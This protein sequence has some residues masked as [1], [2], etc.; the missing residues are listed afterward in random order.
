MPFQACPGIAS[1]EL[2]FEWDGQ[3][4]EIGYHAEQGTAWEE[5]DLMS[6]ATIVYTWWSTTLFGQL[7]NVITGLRAEAKGLDA[8]DSP[9]AIYSPGVLVTGG[10]AQ[11]AVENQVAI[12]IK[13][14]TATGGR[15]GRGRSFIPGLP[16]TAKVTPNRIALG[17]MS[18]LTSAFDDLDT[19]IVAGGYAPVV[20]SRIHDN[21]ARSVG[22][23]FPITSHSY[24]D[25]IV[26]SQRRRAPG[27]G[28]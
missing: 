6:L 21:A 8:L 7:S 19:A 16:Q 27:R 25:N 1:V 5:G 28:S 11:P 23:G 10:V 2:I 24:T 26:D 15:S 22:V 9:Q 13:H 4:V 12:A 18:A 14:N 20:L 3:N 17:V